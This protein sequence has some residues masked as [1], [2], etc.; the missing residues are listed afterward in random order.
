MCNIIK[1]LLKNLPFNQV[2]KIKKEIKHLKVKQ[3]YFIAFFK[4]V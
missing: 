3:I 4:F 1:E 2:R